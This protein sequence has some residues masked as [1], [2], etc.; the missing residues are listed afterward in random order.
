[1][2]S[3]DDKFESLKLRKLIISSLNSNLWAKPDLNRIVDRLSGS[4]LKLEE[5]YELVRV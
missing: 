4:A 3:L 5:D 2:N 1:M